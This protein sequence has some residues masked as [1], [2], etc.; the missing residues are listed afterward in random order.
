MDLYK[1]K[2]VICTSLFGTYL[3]T[4]QQ[5]TP[6]DI[7]VLTVAAT[8]TDLALIPCKIGYKVGS[9]EVEVELRA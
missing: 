7:V 3:G 6:G 4:V 8:T 5:T 1:E 9:L 2:E